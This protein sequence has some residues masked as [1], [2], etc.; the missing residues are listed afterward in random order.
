MKGGLPPLTMPV[1]APFHSRPPQMLFRL[2]CC[3]RP[4]GSYQYSPLHRGR[5]LG[6]PEASQHTAVC[7]PC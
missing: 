6:R 4:G 5:W 1:L 7:K 2:C 3:D